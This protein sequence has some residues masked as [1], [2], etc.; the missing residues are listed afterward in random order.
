M[1]IEISTNLLK[2]AL[3]LLASGA[4][5]A[6]VFSLPIA[7]SPRLA[8]GAVTGAAAFA[9]AS[10]R[11]QND[12]NTSLLADNITTSTSQLESKLGEI[13]KEI[14]NLK[15]EETLRKLN[16]AFNYLFTNQ[17]GLV[18][19]AQ[20]TATAGVDPTLAATYLTEKLKLLQATQIE[21][22]AFV[23]AGHPQPIIQKIEEQ[24]LARIQ[25]AQPQ[26]QAP[27]PSIDVER[28]MALYNQQQAE[29]SREAWRQQNGV[30]PVDPGQAAALGGL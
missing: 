27:T 10:G 11:K 12:N 14:G 15:V 5:G 1:S 24:L 9:W 20:L 16:E 19:L 4:V 6:A 13:S 25:Q 2:S 23:F 17:G 28:L 29:L 26:A 3:K 7:G 30:P 21:P 22:N 18:T 8:M